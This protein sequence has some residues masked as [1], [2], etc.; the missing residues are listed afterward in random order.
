MF[1]FLHISLVVVSSYKY[2]VPQQWRLWFRLT[3]RKKLKETLVL[4][5]LSLFPPC[6]GMR[7][8]FVSCPLWTKQGPRLRA[9]LVIYF[10]QQF[11]HFKHIYI[12]FNILF[13]SHVFQ[14][15]SKNFKQQFS[16]SLIKQAKAQF[17][18][19]F[20]FFS[21]DSGRFE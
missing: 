8:P 12:H 7:N 19:F 18:P 9:C 21:I 3:D 15:I 4:C 11:L 2:L 6:G 20:F 14:N 10:K 17:F 16:N 1:P 5:F 13:H